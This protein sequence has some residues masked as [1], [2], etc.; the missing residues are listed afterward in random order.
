MFSVRRLLG[1]VIAGSFVIVLTASQAGA[2]VDPLTVAQA[3]VQAGSAAFDEIVDADGGVVA[4]PGIEQATA[5]IDDW[6]ARHE[7]SKRKGKGQGP[8]RAQEVHAALAAGE[9]PG[10]INRGSN[11]RLTGLARA[12]ENLLARAD[13]LGVAPGDDSS[14]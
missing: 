4:G 7:N 3:G 2:Q 14:S 12:Y 6:F 8:V 10:Q 13:R 9:I 11:E 5:A 1:A